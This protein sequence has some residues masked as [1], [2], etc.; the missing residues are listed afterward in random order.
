MDR[1]KPVPWPI[2]LVVKNGSNALAITSGVMPV[3]VSVTQMQIYWPGRDL[4]LLRRI[5]VVEVRV[6]GFDRKLAA[7]RHR[8][9]R[10]DREVQDR[11]FELVR[12]AQ[13]GP[14]PAGGDDFEADGLADGAPEQLLHAGDE[15][16]GVDG[17]GVERL[18]AREGEQ[19][20]REGR[21]AVGGGHGG[22][23]V[24]FDVA[25]PALAD[26]A[27]HAYRGSR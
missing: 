19:T 22:A 13:R 18:A 9:A 27:L 7:L 6:A 20:V 8:V 17:L 24:A 10:V 3:P 14:E 11:A 15:P 23:G 26:A 2:G 21:G 16:V 12:V 4:A 1:P 25:G 5:G